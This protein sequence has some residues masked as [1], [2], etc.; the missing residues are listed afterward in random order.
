MKNYKLIRLAALNL[1]AF[2]M[3]FSAQAQEI[4]KTPYFIDLNAADGTR[5]YEL[6]DEMLSIH[7]SDAYGR[8]K[9]IPMTIYNWKNDVVATLNLDKAYGLNSYIINLREFYS[10]WEFNQVYF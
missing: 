7:Y 3:G 6:R 10:S 1:V 8:N 2:C 4:K 9:E 5:S